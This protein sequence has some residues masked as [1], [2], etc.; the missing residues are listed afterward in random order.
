M[1]SFYVDILSFDGEIQ[2]FAV[3]LKPKRFLQWDMQDIF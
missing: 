1:R 3:I 2:Q